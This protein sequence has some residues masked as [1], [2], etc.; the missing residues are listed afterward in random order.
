MASDVLNQLARRSG[1]PA[2][3]GSARE[4]NPDY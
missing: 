1:P 2:K 4:P 3:P